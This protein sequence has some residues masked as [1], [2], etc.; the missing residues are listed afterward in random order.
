RTTSL[1]R[2]CLQGQPHP[3]TLAGGMS[4]AN[5]ISL[6]RALIL[7]VKGGPGFGDHRAGRPWHRG[8]VRA[9]TGATIT[10]M[11]TQLGA[12]TSIFPSDD[13]TRAF[14]AAEG[15]EADFTPLAQSAGRASFRHLINTRR[16]A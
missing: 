2:T 13:V 15:R 12:T 1:R 5:Y 11:G 7:S 6:E 14:L 8:A 4:A 9:R 16:T 10:N 3:R